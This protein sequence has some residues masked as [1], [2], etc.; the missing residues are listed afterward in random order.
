MQQEYLF[1]NHQKI[2]ADYV[3]IGTGSAGSVLAERLS[4]NGRYKV[5]IIESGG[6]DASPFINIPGALSY[7]MNMH[8]FDWGYHAKADPGL[9][10]RSIACPRG[11]VIGGSSSINGMIYVR[12]HGCDYDHWQA[13]GAEGW[14]YKDVLPYFKQIETAHDVETDLED[15]IQPRRGKQGMLHVT[16][17]KMQTPLFHAFLEAMDQAGYGITK[18]YNGYRQEGGCVFDRT[19]WKGQRWSAAK[20]WLHDA[21]TRSNVMLYKHTHCDKVLFHERH[22][23]GVSATQGGRKLLIY[24]AKEVVVSAGA[25]NSPLLLMRSGI[26]KPTELARHQID[27]VASRA[28]VGENL[29]DHLEVYVQMRCKE[30]VSLSPW[31]SLAGK[32]AA[33]GLWF[34]GKGPAISNQFEAGAFIRTNAGI[35]YPNVQIHFLPVAVRYDG[36]APEKGHGFQMHVGPMR[37][38]SRGWIKLPEKPG[39]K[40]EIFFNYLSCESDM[41]DF[42]TSI[43][44]VQEIAR[45][46]AMAKYCEHEISPGESIDSDEKLDDFIRNQCESAYHP[47]GTCRMGRS[48]DVQAVVDSECRVIGVTGLRVAD[49]SIFPQIT[50]GNLNAPSIMVGAKAAGH[51]TGQTLSPEPLDYFIDDH[52][53]THQR[54]Q[55]TK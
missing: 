22:A 38:K 39:H 46:N 2:Y 5:A 20:A 36:K 27:L 37:S 18:D 10:G 33:A 15:L 4:A 3:V 23:Y 30:R 35:E 1:K 49:S 34:L 51:I 52:W 50:N 32:A 29:Q 8:Q 11:H 53:K 55:S 13:L 40:P 16:R 12:G 17:G 45:Q 48:D 7:P 42:R 44:L 21:C 25:I 28:G 9:N 47:C 19:I 41:E 24:A 43:R 54:I 26:G 31:L 14:A 6:S